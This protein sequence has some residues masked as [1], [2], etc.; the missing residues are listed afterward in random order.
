MNV[1][2]LS[3]ILKIKQNEINKTFYSISSNTN[4]KFA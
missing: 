4:Y 3:K 2:K 1:Q